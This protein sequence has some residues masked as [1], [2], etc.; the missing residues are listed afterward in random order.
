MDPTI[1]K[2]QVHR[3]I[4]SVNRQIITKAIMS[5]IDLQ[6]ITNYMLTTYHTFLAILQSNCNSSLPI[7]ILGV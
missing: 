4:V 2:L 6:I 3:Q 5:K 7:F 1:F